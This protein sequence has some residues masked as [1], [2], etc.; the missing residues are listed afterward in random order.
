MWNVYHYL[1]YSNKTCF[2]MCELR[3][4]FGYSNI[5]K[6]CLCVPGNLWLHCLHSQISNRQLIVLIINYSNPSHKSSSSLIY[7][8]IV[9]SRLLHP[10]FFALN[11]RRPWKGYF[12]ALMKIHAM[13]IIWLFHHHLP[14]HITLLSFTKLHLY[15]ETNFFIQ[16]HSQ[17][18]DFDSQHGICTA[19]H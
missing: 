13:I 17:S 12:G 6:L 2:Y 5:S 4:F 7:E 15:L 3:V 14:N 8:E 19:T 1:R 16:W 18:A 11:E 9:D 10:N